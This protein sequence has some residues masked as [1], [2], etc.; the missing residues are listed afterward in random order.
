MLRPSWVSQPA[1]PGFAGGGEV[2]RA[3]RRGKEPQGVSESVASTD[4]RGAPGAQPGCPSPAVRAT[5]PLSCCPREGSAL[6][7]IL[8]AF[9]REAMAR[10]G[11]EHVPPVP[12]RAGRGEPAS[13]CAAASA[14][15]TVCSS[16]LQ[17]TLLVTRARLDGGEG[18]R[19]GLVFMM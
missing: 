11:T 15:G 3:A 14:Q 12:S 8:Y 6:F 18:R 13:A 4:G 7:S 10:G 5:S 17:G 19:A 9:C 2:T 16:S 1:S